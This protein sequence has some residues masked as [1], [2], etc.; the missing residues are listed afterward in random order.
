MKNIFIFAAVLC[1]TTAALAQ[2]V[3]KTPISI[4][5]IIIDNACL[6]AHKEDLG[7]F[8]KTHVKECAVSAKAAESGYSIYAYG[9]LFK[10]D[11]ESNPRI[12]RFLKTV[13]GSL[14]VNCLVEKKGQELKLVSIDSQKKS[15]KAAN[16]GGE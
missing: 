2:L 4:S 12:A 16:K 15:P 14:K 3:D 11:K 5:G 13:K 1:I 9:E 8:I 6:D 7:A 10:F